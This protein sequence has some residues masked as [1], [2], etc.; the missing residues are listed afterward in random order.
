[1]CSSTI[2]SSFYEAKRKLHDLGLGYK[3]IHACKYD[4]VWYLKEF[5]NLQHCP[6][7]GETRYKIN[8]NRRKKF[9]EMNVMFLEF[10]NDLYN[11]AK[12]LSSVGDNSGSSS[13]PPT[14]PT[15]TPRRRV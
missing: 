1:M 14:T 6:T 8:R 5:A 2:P 13:Q 12:G 11:L 9:L 10:A 4:C 7:C 3:T 15:P